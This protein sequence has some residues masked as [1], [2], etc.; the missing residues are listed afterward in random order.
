[1]G[2]KDIAEALNKRHG[3]KIDKRKIVLKEAIKEPGVYQAVVKI[4]PSIQANMN[5][6]VLEE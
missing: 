1:V 6:E 5:V 3:F 2:S 4:Y